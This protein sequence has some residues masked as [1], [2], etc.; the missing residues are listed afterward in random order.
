MVGGRK[1]REGGR[2]RRERENGW[3]IG[4]GGKDFKK[5]N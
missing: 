3:E 4:R 5:E 2:K 1:G